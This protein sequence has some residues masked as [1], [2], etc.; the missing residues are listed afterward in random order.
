MCCLAGT[1]HLLVCSRYSSH[2]LSTSQLSSAYLEYLPAYKILEDIE[3]LMTSSVVT[4]AQLDTKFHADSVEWCRENTKYLACGTYQLIEDSQSDSSEKSSQ[5]NSRIGSIILLKYNFLLKN[6]VEVQNIPTFAI[7]DVKWNTVN[8]STL[9]S[10]AGSS[11]K[12]EV[13]CLTENNDNAKLQ[14][15][16]SFDICSP[17]LTLSLDWGGSDKRYFAV[18]D[19]RGW[20][21]ILSIKD[22]SGEI[23]IKQS[24]KAHTFD[25]W[26]VANDYWNKSI[27]FSG[28]DDCHL[29]AWDV[30][31]DCLRPTFVNK[32]H[33]MGVCA[34]QSSHLHEHLFSSG[35]YDELVH[36]WDHRMIKDP[37]SSCNVGGGIWR[38]KWHPQK[39]NYLLA[40]CC[41]SGF[42][43]LS[44]NDQ[45]KFN[46][47]VIASYKAH[48]S[49]AYG[50]DWGNTIGNN[51]DGLNDVIG[52]CS[53]YDHRFDLW[54][55]NYPTSF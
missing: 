15:L 32:H 16:S 17:K 45:E 1:Q 38:L 42:H 35:G 12:V 44:I 13:Y 39:A 6:V 43:V 50:A 24:W 23:V 2:V 21:T 4:I 52:T 34:I 9:L 49:L 28:G 48:K 41:H 31:T 53:F 10:V 3:F 5:N 37:L 11:G 47:Q 18:S 27:V 22:H 26:V 25:A 7:T 30:R 54:Q 14:S 46:M 19:S 33:T 20:V 40:A 36:I 51:A 55:I 29:K 8:N